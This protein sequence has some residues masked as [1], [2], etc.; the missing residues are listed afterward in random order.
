MTVEVKLASREVAILLGLLL[1]ILLAF[2]FETTRPV[3]KS[4]DEISLLLFLFIPIVAGLL[5][6]LGDP[7]DPVRNGAFVGVAAGI[8]NSLI[9]LT[10]APRPIDSGVAFF[11]ILSVL[12]WGLLSAVASTLS[13]F[14]YSTRQTMAPSRPSVS[15]SRVCW[16]CQSRNPGEARY[17]HHCGQRL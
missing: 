13:R 10:V 4:F 6:G 2:V 1:G 5:T 3:A 8:T 11:L 16:V 7:R 12:M 14:V 9:A 17:C 15:S